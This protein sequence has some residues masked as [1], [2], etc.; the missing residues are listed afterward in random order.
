MNAGC[1]RILVVVFASTFTACSESSFYPITFVCLPSFVLRLSGAYKAD[2]EKQ[3]G[4]EVWTSAYKGISKCHL[5]ISLQ[6]QDSGA[7]GVLSSDIWVKCG[8]LGGLI[9]TV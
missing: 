7:G 4:G 5:S 6:M 8:I 9:H 1:W 2:E 3:V